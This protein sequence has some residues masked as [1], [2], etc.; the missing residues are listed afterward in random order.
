MNKLVFVFPKTLWAKKNAGLFSGA[1]FFR[2]VFLKRKKK[3]EIVLYSAANCSRELPHIN[4]NSKVT[5]EHSVYIVIINF[6]ELQTVR[7]NIFLILAP[8]S[9]VLQCFNIL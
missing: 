9:L 6:F 5:L 1:K 2:E 4:L 7:I 8:S 3:T